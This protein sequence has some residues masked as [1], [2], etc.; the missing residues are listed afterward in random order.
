MTIK[1][2]NSTLAKALLT[3][4]ANLATAFDDL[5]W[6]TKKLGW[7]YNPLDY[8]SE[9]AKNYLETYGTEPGRKALWLGM[10]PGPWGMAQTGVPFGDV[11]AARDWMGLSGEVGEPKDP[12]DKREIEGYSLSRREGS[13]KRLWGWIEQRWGTAVNFFDECFVWNY[14]PLMFL[15]K[16]SARNLTPNNLYKADREGL[17]PICDKALATLIEALEPEY[18]IGVGKFAFTRAKIVSKSL[19]NPPKIATVLHPS[20]ASPAANAG[21][22]E[23]AEAQL[24]EQGI[25]FDNWLDAPPEDAIIT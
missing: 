6:T 20:P 25:L 14:C 12:C 23:K 9:P 22:V 16:E 4:N 19:E 2:D 10:N 8:A 15:E 7:I 5:E 11:V 24:A 13:G 1:K 3:M 21:W 18:V 17:F